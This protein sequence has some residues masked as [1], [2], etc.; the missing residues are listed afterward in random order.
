MGLRAAGRVEAALPGSVH[1]QAAVR[2][3][4]PRS[5]PRPLGA[6]LRRFSG[7][8]EEVLRCGGV[9]TA[10]TGWRGQRSGLRWSWISFTK[11]CS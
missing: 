3:A 6:E 4:Q 1:R 10:G 5:L 7:G 9:G 2:G 11:R 8:S